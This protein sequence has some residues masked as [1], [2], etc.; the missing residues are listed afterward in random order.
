MTY[1]DTY[2][3]QNNRLFLVDEKGQSHDFCESLSVTEVKYNITT[4][5]S[6]LVVKIFLANG[7]STQVELPRDEAVMNPLT[8][9]VKHGLSVA[10][11]QIYAVT[12]SEILMDLEKLAPISYVHSKQGFCTIND[13]KIF[14]SAETQTPL[15]ISRHTDYEKLKPK[16]DFKSWRNGALSFFADR[17]ETSLAVAMGASAPVASLLET[18]GVLE[19]SALWGLVGPSSRSKTTI[20]KLSASVWGVPSTKGLISTLLDTENYL[21]GM[22]TM[23]DGHPV[24]IDENSVSSSDFTK[25]IYN[26][27]MSCGR[28]RCNPDGTLKPI[29]RWA[30]CSVTVTGERSMLSQSNKNGGLFSRIVEFDRVWAK[31]A[32]T[33]ELI[34]EF[35]THQHGTAGPVFIEHLLNISLSDLKEQYISNIKSLKM[36]VTPKNGIEERILKKLA[37]LRLTIQIMHD[38]WDIPVD[39]DSIDNILI[40]TFSLN[41]PKADRYESIYE[42]LLQYV[43]SHENLF[44]DEKSLKTPA[45][46]KIAKQGMTSKYNHQACVWIMSDFFEKFLSDRGLEP[47]SNALHTMKDR[48]MIVHFKDRFRKKQELSPNKEILCYCLLLS[49]SAPSST[50]TKKKKKTTKSKNRHILLSEDNDD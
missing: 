30:A 46:A 43:S 42:S 1:Y 36:C 35:V 31:D 2:Y 7:S 22:L 44:P 14:L 32:A 8:S 40:E 27:A 33:S 21:I 12:I 23:Q 3:N 18:A 48:K 28:G 13:T 39:I 34:S 38:A 19:E 9:L 47:T 20:L 16:G 26:L 24:F 45:L 4:Q 17:A 11:V 25:L 6:T 41:A 50:T 37:L 15:G 49:N 10:N 5:I 29:K